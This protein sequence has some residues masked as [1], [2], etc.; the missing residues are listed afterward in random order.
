MKS[1]ER[2]QRITGVQIKLLM[3]IVALVVTAIVGLYRHR[4]IQ[5]DDPIAF[6][7]TCSFFILFLLYEW[8]NKVELIKRCILATLFCAVMD[9]CFQACR[10]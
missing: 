10:I 5:M 1:S 8:K 4:G 7:I 3:L 9:D 2:K 6:G